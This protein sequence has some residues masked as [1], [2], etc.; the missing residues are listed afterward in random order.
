MTRFGPKLSTSVKILCTLHLSSIH[1]QQLKKLVTIHLKAI[2]QRKIRKMNSQ[3]PCES[4]TQVLKF[5]NP[6]LNHVSSHSWP[7][8][9]NI[10]FPNPRTYFCNLLTDGT[11]RIILFLLHLFPFHHMP[12]LGFEPRRVELTWDL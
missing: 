2:F 5:R 9:W 10:F 3:M 4:R 8:L 7:C 12:R 1:N 6:M 11:A